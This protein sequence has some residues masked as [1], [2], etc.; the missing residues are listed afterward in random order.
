MPVELALDF[1]RIHCI[2]AVVARTVFDE[3][4]EL[5]VRNNGIIRPQLV[6]QFADCTHDLKILFLASTSDIVGF[7]H[8][9]PSEHGANRAAMVFHI[10]PVT[11][12]LTVP[13]DR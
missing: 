12:I 2:A 11:H 4:D 10:E 5:L 8:A 13:V 6:E 9:A 3:S 7:A 1:A